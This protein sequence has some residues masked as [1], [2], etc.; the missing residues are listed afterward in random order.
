MNNHE[1]IKMAFGGIKAPAGITGEA[2]YKA[3][4]EIKREDRS[5]DSKPLVG[6]IVALCMVAVMIFGVYYVQ[7]NFAPG[8]E[9]DGTVLLPGA[10][11]PSPSPSSE[12]IAKQ[13]DDPPDLNMKQPEASPE[14]PDCSHYD[15]DSWSYS[16]VARYRN[17][18]VCDFQIAFE[19]LKPYTSG[20]WLESNRERHILL[21]REGLTRMIPW[22]DGTNA[23][24]PVVRYTLEDAPRTIVSW[25]NRNPHSDTGI[26]ILNGYF[27]CFSRLGY[28]D[29]ELGYT[30][31]SGRHENSVAFFAM[32]D[33]MQQGEDYILLSL[34]LPDS[35]PKRVC[36]HNIFDYGW[37]INGG[38]MGYQQ[39]NDD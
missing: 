29:I 38:S 5:Y 32:N 4:A 11:E 1:K 20:M 18:T 34:K 14:V 31:I 15:P 37:Q 2:I 39:D 16:E 25:F 19:F 28:T 24:A 26:Y 12:S 6:S 7:S 13:P 21:E 35:F 10:G 8:G 3:E 27:W 30:H 22:Y 33:P 9:P 17:C 36:A 23:D